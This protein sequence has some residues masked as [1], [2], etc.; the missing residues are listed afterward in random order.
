MN[1]T[2]VS[3]HKGLILKITIVW[4]CIFLLVSFLVASRSSADPVT[5][6]IVPEVPKTGEPIVATFNIANPS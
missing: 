3:Q 6:S 2:E 1:A 4:L 5:M